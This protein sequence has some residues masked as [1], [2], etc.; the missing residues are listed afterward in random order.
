M[1]NSSCFRSHRVEISMNFTN[2][3]TQTLSAI[4]IA[5]QIIFHSCLTINLSSLNTIS[6][7]LFCLVQFY[8]KPIR[9]QTPLYN[10]VTFLEMSMVYYF[11]NYLS[12][13]ILMSIAYGHCY[14]RDAT[15][16]LVHKHMLV[17]V[18]AHEKEKGRESRPQAR[19]CS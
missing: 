10:N 3:I 12:A 17:C 19:D 16:I 13:A 15:R 11:H 9:Y 1:C 8:I 2:N 5:F 6:I 4:K 14:E 18:L 7:E